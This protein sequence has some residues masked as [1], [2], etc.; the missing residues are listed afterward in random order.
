MDPSTGL[1]ETLEQLGVLLRLWVDLVVLSQPLGM[2]PGLRQRERHTGAPHISN[3]TLTL[4]MQDENRRRDLTALPKHCHWKPQGFDRRLEN[5]DSLLRDQPTC[6]ILKQPSF[7]TVLRPSYPQH[8]EDGSDESTRQ[9]RSQGGK[10]STQNPLRPAEDQGSDTGKAPEQ[11]GREGHPKST[12]PKEGV[13]CVYISVGGLVHQ[14][15][16][17][18]ATLLQL[19]EGS[20]SFI[21]SREV[22]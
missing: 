3:Q 5:Q 15:G 22:T 8:T 2:L 13:P 6:V 17:A 9:D 4:R 11:E 20:T 14:C 7:D 21:L 19:P 18:E 16:A 12:A 10:R 1:F